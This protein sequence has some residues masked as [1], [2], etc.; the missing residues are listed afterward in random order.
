MR[1]Q[2]YTDSMYGAK[3]DYN[4]ALTNCKEVAR[5]DRGD[6]RREARTTRDE[7]YADARSRR[8]MRMERSN[9]PNGD[10]GV[11]APGERANAGVKP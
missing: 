9:R 1:N 11:G 3:Q 10:A 4:T 8:Q 6:C 2:R 7:A 5:A